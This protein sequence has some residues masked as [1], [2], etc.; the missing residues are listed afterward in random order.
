M[1]QTAPDD[2]LDGDAENVLRR[3]SAHVPELARTSPEIVRSSDVLPAPLAPST[4]VTLPRST[5]SV[6]AVEGP[7]RAVV[8]TQLLDL[9]QAAPRSIAP[10]CAGAAR[11][12]LLLAPR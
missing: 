9:Q 12:A 3:P 10:A 11:R 4:A 5:A 7:H 8:G 6:T 2:V 1:G